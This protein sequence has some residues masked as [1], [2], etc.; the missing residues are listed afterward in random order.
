MTVPRPH[1]PA[2]AR[3]L[4]VV[5]EDAFVRL[6]DGSL[7][8][9][10]S[11][12][13]AIAE[14]L[15]RLDVHPGMRVLE[16][17]T[18]SGYSTALLAALVGPTGR[19]VSIDV[20]PD[21]VDRAN[22]LLSR[23]GIDNVLLSCGDGTGGHP[24]GAR[25]DRVVAW[26]TAPL[27]PRAWV[28]QTVQ[29]GRIVT[30]VALTAL[31]K[32]GAGAVVGVDSHGEPAVSGLFASGYVEM[33]DQVLRQWEVPPYGADAVHTAVDGCWWLSSEQ[34]RGTAPPEAAASALHHFITAPQP[35]TGP[36][37]DGESIQDLRAWLI[38]KRPETLTTAA[39][40][41]PLWRIGSTSPNGGAL[42]STIDGSAVVAGDREHL[43]IVERWAAEWRRAGRPSLLDVIAQLTLTTGGWLVRAVLR[44]PE[45]RYVEH[46][47]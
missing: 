31:S 14:A 16:I 27:L 25:F 34:Y 23:H 44:S 41:E 11:S 29:G 32:T 8:S 21:L 46:S 1:D 35:V 40:G 17:G 13:T 33:H 24:A 18:G 36:L 20:V 2:V 43:E 7:V 12:R 42:V 47:S 10:S 37:R 39:L 6:G 26:T 5:D 28:D 4:D 38:A 45:S 19:V 15:D 9:Q 30:P 3:A 22:R